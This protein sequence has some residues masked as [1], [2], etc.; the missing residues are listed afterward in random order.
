VP[1]LAGAPEAGTPH[2]AG[3]FMGAGWFMGIGAPTWPGAACI[4]GIRAGP[5]KGVGSCMAVMLAPPSLGNSGLSQ[6]FDA[7]LIRA[8][9]AMR[10]TPEVAT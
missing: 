4:V 10:K 2:L 3:V 5:G 1:E 7:V 8:S 6:Y 9:A